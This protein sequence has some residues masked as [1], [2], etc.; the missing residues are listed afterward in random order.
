MNIFLFVYMFILFVLLTPGTLINLSIGGKSAY[1][2]WIVAAI[3]GFLF[4]AI[5]ITTYSTVNDIYMGM[6][7]STQ[8]NLV[9]VD[10]GLDS[11]FP[12]GQMVFNTPS[13]NP[14]TK[15]KANARPGPQIK[16][17]KHNFCGSVDSGP[18]KKVYCY[19]SNDGC[20]WGVR[21]CKSD[22]DCKKYNDASKR[23]T[24]Y[25]YNQSAVCSTFTA[26]SWPGN[27]CSLLGYDTKK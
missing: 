21:D 15:P 13:E 10:T 27:I 19:G 1:S 9:D 18:N 7:S 26:D 24:D 6:F 20:L 8:E 3:H 23:Y 22:D 16:C 12:D 14:P 4:S 17:G 2:K 11:S 5:A 25:I